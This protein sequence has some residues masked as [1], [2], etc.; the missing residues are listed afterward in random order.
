MDLNI[1]AIH[2]KQWNLIA[3]KTNELD[4]QHK[5]KKNVQLQQEKW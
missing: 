4:F 2:V 1:L 3:N 5:I